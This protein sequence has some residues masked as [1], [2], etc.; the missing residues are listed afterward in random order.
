LPRSSSCSASGGSTSARAIRW[1]KRIG[2]LPHFLRLL[3][4]I[5]SREAFSPFRFKFPRPLYP[6]CT[7]RR[8]LGTID[9][10]SY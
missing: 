9:L 6:G 1:S 4:G 7:R 10:L 8:C 3:G 2:A 5:S